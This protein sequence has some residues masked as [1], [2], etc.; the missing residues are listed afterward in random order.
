MKGQ[1][2]I[3]QADSRYS[4]VEMLKSTFFVTVLSIL[5]VVG[6]IILNTY[7]EI[8]LLY[9][10]ALVVLYGLAAVYKSIYYNRSKL[11]L[12][13]DYVY[14]QKGIFFQKKYYSLYGDIKDIKTTRY[15][16]SKLGSIQFNVAGEHLKK[17][18]KNKAIKAIKKSHSFKINYVPEIE[19]KDDLID[20]IF[21]KRPNRGEVKEIEEN[22]EDYKPETILTSNPDFG[23]ALVMGMIPG[24]IAFPITI[25]LII[26]WIKRKSY[27]LQSYRVV[28]RSGIV[29]RRQTS[30]VFNKIDHISHSQQMLNKIFKNGDITVNTAGSSKPELI[31][32]SIPDFREFYKKLKSKYENN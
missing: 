10:L 4:F 24:F 30:I 15:P 31:I 17:Q 27:H 14:F 22:I 23:N 9:L 26:W 18:G 20:L 28:A 3:Y 2:K 21:F 1:E 19:T 13:K 25:P 32:K 6:I 16:L 7:Y 8:S 5:I 12:F 11:K 29:Y